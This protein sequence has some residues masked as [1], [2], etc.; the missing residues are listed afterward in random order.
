[1][2]KLIAL[3]LCC[4]LVSIPFAGAVQTSP[5]AAPTPKKVS[6][7]TMNEYELLKSL[8]SESRDTLRQMGYTVNQI[9]EIKNLRSAYAD[10]LEEISHYDRAALENLGYTEAQIDTLQNFDGS[11]SQ[12]MSL[13]AT[14]NFDLS[15]DYVTW[16]STDNRT[17][18][19]VYYKFDWNGVPLVKKNDLVAVSWNDWTINGK[20]SYITY[21]PVNGTGTSEIRAATYVANNGPTAMGGAFKFPMLINNSA[22][23]AKSGYGIFTLYYNNYR[24]DLSTYAAYGHSTVRVVPTFSIPGYGSISFDKDTTTPGEAWADMACSN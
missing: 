15:I 6:S 18:A 14:M 17:N 5:D 20:I 16:S 8:S 22:N 4:L 10:H 13:A 3:L 9:S 12:I 11:E 1:M 23:W 7:Y 21:V 24:K 19:R 2:K